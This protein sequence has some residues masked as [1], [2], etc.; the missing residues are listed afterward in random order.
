MDEPTVYLEKMAEA[1]E[2]ISASE[3]YLAQFRNSGRMFE[4]ES[5]ALQLRKAMEAM[6][7]ASIA[8]NK[9]QYAAIRKNAEKSADF[10]DDWK[11]DSIFL[12]LGK[13]NPD[14]YPDPL[15]QQVQ[16]A[17]GRWH[18]GKPLGGYM[19]RKNF[20][21]LYKRLG[22]F[23]HADNPWGS[24]KGWTQLAQDLPDAIT[25]IRELLKIHRTLIRAAE[26]NGVWIVEA[27]SDGTPPRMIRATAQGA[28]VV[29]PSEGG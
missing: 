24:D 14:F 16:I 5:A 29:S 10:G 9:H 11:A 4:L 21:T 2:R 17:P 3:Q 25:K 12:I 26:F 22:K 20:E 23:L 7:F 15:L 28:F 8:P 13:V 18:Y 27:P 6:A 19:K 1:L